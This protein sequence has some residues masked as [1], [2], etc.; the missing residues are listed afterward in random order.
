MSQQQ[1]LKT[2]KDVWENEGGALPER[3][4]SGITRFLTE[5]YVIDGHAYASLSDASARRDALCE[6]AERA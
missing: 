1:A 5:M 6:Q 3:E 4:L 2:A